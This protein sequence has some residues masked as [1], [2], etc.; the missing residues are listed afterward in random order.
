MNDITTVNLVRYMPTLDFS[1]MN[2]QID[3]IL[4]ISKFF[5][6]SLNTPNTL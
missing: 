3:W 2:K 4:I 6:L 1:V 5:Q